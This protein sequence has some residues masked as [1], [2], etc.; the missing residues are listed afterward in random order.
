MRQIN[1]SLASV[2]NRCKLYSRTSSQCHVRNRRIFHDLLVV[3]HRTYTAEQSRKRDQQLDSYQH[4]EDSQLSTAQKV[5]ETSKTV[6]YLGVILIGVGVTALM[7]FT[8]GKELFSANSPNAIYTDALKLCKSD[9]RVIDAIG[10]P[11]KGFGET[12]RRG[13]RKHVRMNLVSTTIGTYL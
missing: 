9:E 10:E 12:T 7:F 3:P 1:P 6:S 2:L 4:D 13:W 11:I 8:I 5:V